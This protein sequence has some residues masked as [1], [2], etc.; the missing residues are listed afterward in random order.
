MLSF[1]SVDQLACAIP[2]ASRVGFAVSK[3]REEPKGDCDPMIVERID[4]RVLGGERVTST[5]LDIRVEFPVRSDT[6]QCQ[7]V[8]TV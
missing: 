3:L 7:I 1:G 5:N 8:F 2:F 4:R 6:K